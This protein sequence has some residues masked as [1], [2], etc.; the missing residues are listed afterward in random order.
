MEPKLT[1][2]KMQIKSR[3]DHTAKPGQT[4]FEKSPKPFNS[5]NV[6]CTISK[7]IPPMINTKMFSIPHINKPIVTTPPIRVDDTI[8][9]DPA[10]DDCL[11]HDF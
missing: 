7:F 8:E 5:I 10:P 2:F 1:F 11:E 6:C 3:F 9:S 4:N